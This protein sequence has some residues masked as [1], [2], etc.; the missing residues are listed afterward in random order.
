MFFKNYSKPLVGKSPKLV[1]I[2]GGYAQNTTQSFNDNGESDLDL[3]YAM[4]LVYP[5]E[6]LLLQTGDDV[7]GAF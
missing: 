5:Q 6:I 7:E 4:S 2:D 1:S 3:E